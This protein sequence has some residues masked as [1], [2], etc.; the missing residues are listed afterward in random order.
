MV[1]C[2][3]SDSKMVESCL[4]D[5]ASQYSQVIQRETGTSKMVTLTLDQ[6]NKLP[7]AP[8]AGAHGASC[9]GGVVLACQDGA[10]TIDNTI[11]S[12]LGLVLEQAKPTI[13]KL[14]FK[15]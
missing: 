14:L 15:D 3:A 7:A 12:R 10:I 2:R 13:R 6:A 9:L 4:A 8:V 11:D 5:A 1:R